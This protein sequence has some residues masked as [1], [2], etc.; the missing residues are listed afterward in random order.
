MK[1]YLNTNKENTKIVIE[2]DYSNTRYYS[3]GYY[4]KVYTVITQIINNKEFILNS[5][6][7]MQSMLILGV[8]RKSKSSYNKALKLSNELQSKLIDAVIIK[9]NLTPI[10]L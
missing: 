2:L 5:F 4:L 7:N 9:A 10:N 6:D 1:T 3:K 8:D